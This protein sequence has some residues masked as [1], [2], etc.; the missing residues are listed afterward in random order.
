[1]KRLFFL[2]MLFGLLVSFDKSAPKVLIF[3]RDGSQ[4]LEYMLV[5]EVSK[6]SEILKGAGFEVTTATIAGEVLK[7]GSVTITPDLKLSDVDMDDYAGLML[8]CLVSD[9]TSSDVVTL[10]KEAVNKGKPIAAQA[11]G[12][13]TLA[14]A[15]ILNGRKYALV[16]DPG[17]DPDF[18]NGIYSGTGVVR[19]GIIITS[20]TCPWIAKGTGWEDGTSLLTRTLIDVINNAPSSYQ[21]DKNTE[22]QVKS[23]PIKTALLKAQ[24]LTQEGK[25]EE[26]S[27]IYTSIMEN[28]PDNREAVQ[29]WIVANMKRT[30]TGEEEMIKSL[31]ELGKSY[32]RNTAILFFKTFVEFEYNHIEEALTDID[33]LSLMQPDS[34]DNWIMKGQILSGINRYEEAVVAFDKATSLKPERSDVWGSKAIALARTGKF[35]DAITAANKGLELA[36][37]NPV[38][39]YNRACIY[40]LKGDKTKAL[41]DL[42]KAILLNPSFKEYARKDED[43]RTLTDDED[44]KKLTL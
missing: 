35:D 30:Q 34:A 40:S 3:L 33:R 6:M 16:R 15:G 29:G 21:F 19:D 9:M 26:A 11:G 42:Q 17:M 24:S 23:D 8:P 32:P 28:H 4:Q 2:F 18:N 7:A 43:F 20:G 13:L 41:E 10:A 37:G 36:P 39:I 5:N 12:V 44:F 1:M 31:E 25:I 22:T 27:E 14:K 38:I